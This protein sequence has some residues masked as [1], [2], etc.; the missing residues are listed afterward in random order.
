MITG[1]FGDSITSLLAALKSFF[2]IFEAPTNFESKIDITKVLQN[3]VPDHHFAVRVAKRP[4]GSA[5]RSQVSHKTFRLITYM[6]AGR[7][8]YYNSK[9]HSIR[10]CTESAD[11]CIDAI[12]ALSSDVHTED[13]D[14]EPD[15]MEMAEKVD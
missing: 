8:V 9:E 15:D 7:C 1:T 5:N 12:N 11:L 10:D 2:S 13:A 6:P 14:H 3:S 4:H